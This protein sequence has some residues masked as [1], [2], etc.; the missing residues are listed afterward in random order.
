MKPTTH[1]HLVPRL[2]MVEA[3]LHCFICF[4]GVH[5][6]SSTDSHESCEIVLKLWEPVI[7]REYS[8]ID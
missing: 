5:I 7:D 4:C 2:R 1:L 6:D 3:I 8:L